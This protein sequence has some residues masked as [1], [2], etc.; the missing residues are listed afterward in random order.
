LEE[1][2]S[3][4]VWAVKAGIPGLETL[5]PLVLTLVHKNKLTLDLAMKLLVD[6]PSEIFGLV[7]RGALK[8]GNFADLV[9][10]DFNRKYRIDA[11][12]FKSKAKFTPFDKWVC[13]GKV[14][15]T[16]VNGNLVIDGD[17]I[18]DKPDIGSLLRRAQS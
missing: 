8:Q 12:K 14:L 3:T 6:R 16:Y 5:L 15:K 9:V 4:S 7:D 13:Q 1:K 11:S 17:M 10:V 18:V 2:E